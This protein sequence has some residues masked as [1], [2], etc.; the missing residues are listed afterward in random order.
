MRRLYK[1]E[2]PQD[3]HDIFSVFWSSSFTLLHAAESDEGRVKHERA[4]SL[5][6]DS[7]PQMY[8]GLDSSIAVQR[9]D[10]ERGKAF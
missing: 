1:M 2:K 7:H 8:C 6:A 3:L 10:E 9:V 5:R 4:A